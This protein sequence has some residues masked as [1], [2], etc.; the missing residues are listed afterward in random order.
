[1][2]FAHISSWHSIK[3]FNILL[4]TK[5]IKEP[6]ILLAT[7]QRA[8]GRQKN[9]SITLSFFLLGKKMNVFKMS[10]RGTWVVQSVKSQTLDFGSG[11]DLTVREFEPHDGLCADSGEPA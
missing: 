1:M 11:H 8:S 4:L 5:W 7:T 3:T 9:S 10:L 6:V 2:S